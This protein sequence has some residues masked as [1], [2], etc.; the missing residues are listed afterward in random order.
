MWDIPDSDPAWALYRDKPWPEEA[1]RY[2]AKFPNI[3][4]QNN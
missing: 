3:V 2:A 4:I 1:K